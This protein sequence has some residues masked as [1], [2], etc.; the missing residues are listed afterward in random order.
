MYTSYAARQELGESEQHR[1]MMQRVASLVS[2]PEGTV[3][4]I[5]IIIISVSIMF[6]I[7]S[8]DDYE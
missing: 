5:I 4:I 1:L 2:L 7:V 8:Y 3:I 6:V